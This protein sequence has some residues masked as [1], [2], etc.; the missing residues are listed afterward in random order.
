VIAFMTERAK[1]CIATTLVATL[2][3]WPQMY[4]PQ[5]TQQEPNAYR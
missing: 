5:A 4:W 2:E 3:D 1:S